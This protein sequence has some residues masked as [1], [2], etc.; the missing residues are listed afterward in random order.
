MLVAQE[1]ATAASKAKVMHKA[2][3]SQ[4]SC[5][6]QLASLRSRRTQY[7]QGWQKYLGDLIDNLEKQLEEKGTVMA[8]FAATE[9]ALEDKMEQAREQVLQLAGGEVKTEQ[10]GMDTDAAGLAEAPTPTVLSPSPPEL[11]DQED[12]LKKALHAAKEALDAEASEANRERTPR[13]GSKGSIEISDDE[14]GL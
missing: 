1:D 14:T 6:R 9:S 11:K 4:T 13:R 5:Q 2:I 3:A 10:E 8:D 12:G 7:L